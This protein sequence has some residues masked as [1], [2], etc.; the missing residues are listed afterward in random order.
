VA[1]APLA[2]EVVKP[3]TVFHVDLK[4]GSQ[5]MSIRKNIHLNRTANL[6]I[7]NIPVLR[8]MYN[9]IDCSELSGGLCLTTA[10]LG[11]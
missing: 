5:K 10:A 7:G 9:D 11:L 8:R 4:K 1:F 6:F 3:D 2:V